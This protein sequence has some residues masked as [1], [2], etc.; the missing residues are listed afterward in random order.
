LPWFFS[1]FFV[2]LLRVFPRNEKAQP[3][4]AAHSDR[5]DFAFAE[6]AQS[7]I[8]QYR[9]KYILARL[10]QYIEHQAWGNPADEG[11][12]KYLDSSVNI[13]HILPQTPTEKI[14]TAFDKV[15]DYDD[16]VERLGNLTLLEN[17]INTSV[18]NDDFAKKAPG[19]R[20]SSFLLTKSLVEKPKVG[21]NTRLNRAVKDLLMF[22]VWD[23]NAIEER[24]RMLAK[25]AR[26]VWNMPTKG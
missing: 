15:A 12:E 7:K 25:L 11:A 9:M 24:Q 26:Q 2:T 3:D 23:S 19:Y 4:I 1:P 20:Q 22:E 18:S 10:T 17:T 6:L 21:V 8:Q 16:Y 14:K 13:E 5:F